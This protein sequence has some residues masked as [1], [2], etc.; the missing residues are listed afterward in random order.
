MKFD[1]VLPNKGHPYVNATLLI[2]LVNQTEESGWEGFFLWD[3]LGT[4][5]GLPR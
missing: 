4:I 2:E 5:A 1:L 3:H